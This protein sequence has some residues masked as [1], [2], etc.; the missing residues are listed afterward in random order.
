MLAAEQAEGCRVS[1]EAT[2]PGSAGRGLEN[3]QVDGK[4][5]AGADA[6]NERAVVHGATSERR[7]APLR[8][9]HAAELRRDYPHLD[10]RRLALLADRLA[11]L[12]AAR[13]WLDAQEGIVRNKAGDV[14]PVVDRV[15]KWANRAEA[16]LA[17]V[18]AEARAPVP[19]EQALREHLEG[20][21]TGD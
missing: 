7:L 11:R 5:V 1:T 18:E 12:D 20:R 4:P 6:G 19:A 13:T 9:H 2:K 21:R 17:T 16:V 14:Y 15:E 8:D 10:G 3:V